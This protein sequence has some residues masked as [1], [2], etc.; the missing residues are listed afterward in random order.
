MLIL[1]GDLSVSGDALERFFS[2]ENANQNA[3]FKDPSKDPSHRKKGSVYEVLEIEGAVDFLVPEERLPCQIPDIEYCCDQPQGEQDSSNESSSN[4]SSSNENSED[5]DQYGRDEEDTENEG[6][7]AEGCLPVAVQAG[8]TESRGLSCFDKIQTQDFQYHVRP[9]QAREI[10]VR[11]LT[12]YQR[13]SAD[14]HNN[15]AS[16]S[17]GDMSSKEIGTGRFTK[18]ILIN[19][20]AGS[21]VAKGYVPANSCI[22]YSLCLQGYRRAL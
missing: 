22:A 9:G 11:A 2:E 20:P 18:I 5:E 12:V 7:G 16:A 15:D 4:E 3:S 6:E 10:I 13:L 21:V 14:N 17:T 8:L 19:T 1:S